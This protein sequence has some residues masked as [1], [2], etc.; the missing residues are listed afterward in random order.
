VVLAEG[1][2][3]LPGA[4]QDLRVWVVPDFNAGAASLAYAVI[5]PAVGLGTLVTQWFLQ[6]PLAEAATREF[7]V[8]GRW[9]A[10]LVTPVDRTRDAHPLPR[11]DQSP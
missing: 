6:R 4:T 11:K 1:S 8:T 7:H 9:D 3:S 2:A 10:P 5:N